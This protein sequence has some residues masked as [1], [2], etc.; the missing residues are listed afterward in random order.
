MKYKSISQSFK[1][2]DVKEGIVTGYFSSFGTKDSDGD[3]IHKGAFSKT[4]Q[5]WGPSGRKRIKHLLDHDPTKVVGVIQVLKE[6]EFGLYYESKAGTH[7]LGRD[8][9]LMVE[10]GIITEH[11]IG[12]KT[13]KEK[14]SDTHNDIT[15]IKL[16]EGSSLQTWGANEHTPI[17]GLKSIED[18]QAAFQKLYKA[19][20]S[21]N[22][23]EEA[24][25][26]LEEEYKSLA[27]FFKATQPEE[28]TVPERK[29]DEEI[30]KALKKGLNTH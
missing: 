28:T 10:D 24:F 30:L 3:I 17:T 25:L 29:I 19:L 9:L 26:R 16:W 13:I 27:E 18:I 1:D 20:K 15:E 6:D 2:V 7:T 14:Q 11:S 21:G 12:F 22:Y 5:E 23:S 8:F 4:I